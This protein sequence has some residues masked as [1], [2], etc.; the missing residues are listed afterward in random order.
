M[1]ET[2]QTRLEEKALRMRKTGLSHKEIEKILGHEFMFY[3][4]S[5]TGEYNHAT[6]WKI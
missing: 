4:D 2:E 3:K 6:L 1:T 5:I